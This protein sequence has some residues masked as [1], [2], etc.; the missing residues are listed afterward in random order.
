[1]VTPSPLGLRISYTHNDLA[2][3]SAATHRSNWDL[4]YVM[5]NKRVI[6]GVHSF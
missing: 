6:R 1:M 5:N 3:K 4:W 2:A